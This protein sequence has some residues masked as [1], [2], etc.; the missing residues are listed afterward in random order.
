MMPGQVPAPR[1]RLKRSAGWFAAGLEV[2]TALPLLSDAAFRLYIFLCL[3]VERHSARIVWEPMELARLMQ[4]DCQSVTDSLQELCRRGIC[5]RRPPAAGR[6]TKDRL[7]IEICDRFWPYEKPPVEEFGIDQDHYVQQVRQMLLRP[8]CVRSNFSAAD[9]RLAGDLYRR[10]VTLVHIQRAIWLGCA[11]KYASL[12]NADEYAPRAI[13]SLHYFAHLVTEVSETPVGE[14]YW[15]HVEG[16]AFHLE[17][18]WLSRAEQAAN[19]S[20]ETK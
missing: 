14:D 11:R 3:N 18:M 9:E 13:S 19:P 15:K 17:R 7:S 8:A 5:V 16:R 10:G 2:A 1:L 20:Q 12:L 6:F 4:R